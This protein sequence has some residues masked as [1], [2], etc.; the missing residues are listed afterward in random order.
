[1][2]KDL[3]TLFKQAIY[4][5]ENRLSDDIFLSISNQEAKSRRVKLWIYSSAIVLSLAGLIPVIIDLLSQFANSGF[6]EYLSLALL[7]SGSISS[8]WKEF[9]LSLADSLPVM[10]LTLSFLLLFILFISARLIMR[11]F[12]FRNQLLTA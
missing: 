2:K 10:S 8:Y 7:S 12:K 4:Y 9:I 3:N 11:Q 1:V 5:P 6:Y